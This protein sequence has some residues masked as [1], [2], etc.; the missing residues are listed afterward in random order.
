VGRV[1]ECRGGAGARFSRSGSL[2]TLEA[3]DL[4]HINPVL[5]PGCVVPDR[6]TGAGIFD[7]AR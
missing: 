7:F 2:A 4:E 3:G 5:P 1:G 6:P